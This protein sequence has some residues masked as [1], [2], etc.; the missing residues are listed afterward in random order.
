MDRDEKLVEAFALELKDRRNKR[1]LSQEELAH[2]AGVDRSF[3]AKLE[4]FKSQPSLASLYHLSKALGCELPE[5][6][7]ATLVRHKSLQKVHSVS[8][9]LG[10]IPA[11]KGK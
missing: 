5:L 2:R 8:K 4:L 10:P 7:S 6:L 9:K 11:R 3:I 1:N